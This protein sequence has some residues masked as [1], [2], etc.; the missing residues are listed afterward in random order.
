MGSDH[1][2]ASIPLQNHK[3][4]P[5]YK[6]SQISP[7]PELRYT[8]SSKKATSSVRALEGKVIGL[9]VE[10]VTKTVIADNGERKCWNKPAL[11][12]LFDGKLILLIQLNNGMSKSPPASFLVPI[13][14]IESKKF[15]QVP[16]FQRQSSSLYAIPDSSKSE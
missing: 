7:L 16:F 8:G 12:Q 6:Y 13:R 3:H 14:I 5:E 9:D 11:L 10:Y 2:T 4:L 15:H 1:A